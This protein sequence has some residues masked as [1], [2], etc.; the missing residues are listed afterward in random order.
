MTII[1]QWQPN[2]LRALA[3]RRALGFV[4]SIHV[5]LMAWLPVAHQWQY[6]K[7][8]TGSDWPFSR[9]ATII[10]SP[11][12]EFIASQFMKSARVGEGSSF[13]SFWPLNRASTSP[14]RG[15][16]LTFTEA[17]K[18][19][20]IHGTRATAAKMGLYFCSGRGRQDLR[21]LA[22]SNMGTIQS[23]DW[24]FATSNWASRPF[25]EASATK[26]FSSLIIRTWYISN[27]KCEQEKKPQ[28]STRQEPSIQLA[29]CNVS[30]LNRRCP[31]AGALR[32]PSLLRLFSC[33]NAC[34]CLDASKV[35][36][37]GG[38]G[39]GLREEERGG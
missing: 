30:P 21:C 26:S 29:K 39:G 18:A 24:E 12:W 35:E 27:A 33:A 25:L 10:F 4:G 1:L 9:I 23:R 5:L 13:W 22:Q 6:R 20:T 19:S 15:T 14:A 31:R 8:L 37:D 3:M 38:G 28:P 34:P 2:P 17:V 36:R 32:G 7:G 16:L 11:F